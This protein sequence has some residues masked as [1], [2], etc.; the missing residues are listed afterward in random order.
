MSDDCDLSRSIHPEHPDG[1]RFWA[2]IT[3]DPADDEANADLVDLL[4]DAEWAGQVRATASSDEVLGEFEFTVD[5]TEG[6]LTVVGLILD[7]SDFATSN[8]FDWEATP[9]GGGPVTF[10]AGSTI[11]LISGV[12]RVEGS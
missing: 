12:T 7:T 5:L 8:V 10:F 9:P 3:I 4:A 2:S 1:D 6:V 11:T